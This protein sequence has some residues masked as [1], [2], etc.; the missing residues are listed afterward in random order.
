MNSTK[1]SKNYLQAFPNF[2]KIEEDEAIFKWMLWYQAYPIP[3]SDK[4]TVR[5][6]NYRPVQKSST[7][8]LQIQRHIRIITHYA[9]VEF[10]PGV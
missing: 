4:D 9:Q 6:K 1:H 8:S 7:F 3:K 10:R 2:P 5:Q